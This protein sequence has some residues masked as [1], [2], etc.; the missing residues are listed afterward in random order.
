MLANKDLVIQLIPQGDPFIMVDGLTSNDDESTVSSLKLSK[1]NIF[2]KDGYFQEPGIIENIAQTAA[3]RSGYEAYLN[4]ED[5]PMGFIGSV[6]RL[7]LYK[8]PQD[9]DSLSTKITIL[10]RL[11]NALIIEGEVKV[12]KELIAKGEL[13]IFLQ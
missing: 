10:T 5:P 1:D 9:S 13:N 6:K 8:L 3:L 2:C 7:K 11:M 4:K 12:G